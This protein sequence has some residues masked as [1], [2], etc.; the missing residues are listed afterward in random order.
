[1]I[2]IKI[3]CLQQISLHVLYY[4][5][6]LYVGVIFGGIDVGVS[7]YVNEVTSNDVIINSCPG[8]LPPIYIFKPLFCI[9]DCDINL[10]LNGLI[11]YYFQV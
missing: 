1:M 3:Y 7:V 10:I 6:D 2:A 4:L 11:L 5:V 8:S 9:N